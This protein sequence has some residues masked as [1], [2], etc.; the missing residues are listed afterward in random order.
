M[1]QRKIQNAQ[2]FCVDGNIFIIFE[3]TDYMKVFLMIISFLFPLFSS[4]Q[5][6]AEI[7]KYLKKEY[8]Y[9]ET[10]SSNQ[11]QYVNNSI[12]LLNDS[13]WSKYQD[14]IDIFQIKYR[15]LIGWMVEEYKAIVL[16]DN[17]RG[18]YFIIFPFDLR[19]PKSEAISYFKEKYIEQEDIEKYC[20]S[21]ANMFL[22]MGI[23]SKPRLGKLQKISDNQYQISY[24]VTFVN[25]E[26]VY[27]NFIFTFN[28]LYLEQIQIINPSSGLNEIDY[29]RKP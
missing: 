4:S 21:I 29:A 5:N 1:M 25:R 26:K 12:V 23:L 22:S 19:N 10:I 14:T 2:Y 11:P 28:K 9:S 18:K 6:T 17:S 8:P 20:H 13:I 3:K 24:I 15:E 16:S 27:R 7:E